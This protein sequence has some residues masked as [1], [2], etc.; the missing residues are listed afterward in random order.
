MKDLELADSVQFLVDASYEQVKR[1]LSR[2]S[3]GIR[4]MIDEHFGICIVEYMA[5]GAVPVAHASGGGYDEA[6]RRVARRHES[7]H[8]LREA[9][10]LPP[11]RRRVH[12]AHPQ[13][14]LGGGRALSIISKSSGGAESARNMLARW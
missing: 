9:D 6:R 12:V 10:E 7:K 5:A 13:L 2:A 1:E 11:L 14:V 8:L 4:T 3:V